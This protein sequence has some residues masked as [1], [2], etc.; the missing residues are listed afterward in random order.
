[1]SK[2]K[3]L[4]DVISTLKDKESCSGSLKVV[5]SKDQVK[6]FGL[7]NEFEKNMADGKMNAKVILEMDCEGKK[8]RHESSTEFDG[9][10]SHGA[11]QHGFMGRM[12]SHHGHGHMGKCG[13]IKRCGIKDK[14]NK[15]AFLLGVLNQMK[16]EEQND[17]STVLSLDFDDIP[18]EMKNMLREKMLHKKMSHEHGHHCVCKEFSD[19]E[20]L[21]AGLKLFINQNKEVD[22]ITLTIEGKQKNDSNVLHQMNLQ[23]DLRLTW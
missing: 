21:S 4:Y 5:G 7:D 8:V 22:K 11:G 1:M 19:M 15:L 9:Y 2:I 6:I 18:A 16:V 20:I 10:G 3:L 17:K 14:L 13:G 12:F 23:V